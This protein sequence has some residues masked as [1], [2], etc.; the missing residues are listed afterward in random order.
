[1]FISTGAL[2]VVAAIPAFAAMVGVGERRNNN[3]NSN[4]KLSPRK[5]APRPSPIK[6]SKDTKKLSAFRKQRVT[7]ENA[8]TDHL[9]VV[10][11]IHY[12]DGKGGYLNDAHNAVKSE[13][14]PR[15]MTEV[16]DMRPSTSY[17]Y[18]YVK[19]CMG[20]LL[21]QLKFVIIEL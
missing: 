5:K 13:N 3:D 18:K 6:Q 11:E 8:H 17:Y 14:K 4:K 9:I 12:E 1:M 10:G 16:W 21:F 7:V 19:Y 15:E 20:C 2:C